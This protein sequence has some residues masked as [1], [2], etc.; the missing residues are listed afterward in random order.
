MVSKLATTSSIGLRFL[1]FV[2]DSHPCGVCGCLVKE[3]AIIGEKGRGHQKEVQHPV[4][5]LTL[6][7]HSSHGSLRRAAECAQ[8][9]N[10]ACRVRGWLKMAK[11]ARHVA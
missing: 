7:G 11:M 9:R 10:E 4:E 2:A 6:P 1:S 3:L 8:K 5:A